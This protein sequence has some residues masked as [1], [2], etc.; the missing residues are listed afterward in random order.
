MLAKYLDKSLGKKVKSQGRELSKSQE[1]KEEKHE[2]VREIC[3][4]F[5]REMDR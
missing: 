4:L 5:L 3:F 2:I 1:N